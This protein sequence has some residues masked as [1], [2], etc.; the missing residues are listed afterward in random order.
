[1]DKKYSDKN[2]ETKIFRR[3]KRQTVFGQTLA[4]WS[5]GIGSDFGDYPQKW[6]VRSNP[7]KRNSFY[8]GR[9][10]YVDICVKKNCD[11]YVNR[12]FSIPDQWSF[13]PQSATKF[14]AVKI[15]KRDFKVSETVSEECAKE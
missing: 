7:A 9:K 8:E 14:E 11:I 13:Q 15:R 12:F 3:E 6:A 1:M 10:K 5:G 2:D 4:S